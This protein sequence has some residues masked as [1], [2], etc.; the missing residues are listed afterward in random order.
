[1]TRDVLFALLCLVLVSLATG[2]C[3]PAEPPPATGEHRA[4]DPAVDVAPRIDVPIADDPQEVARG[5]ALAGVLPGGF[6]EDL[7][8]YRPS[9]IVD[10]SSDGER[11]V[12]L[13]TATPLADVRSSLLARLEANGWSVAPEAN[14][15][16]LLRQ[17]ERRARLHL[18]SDS[19]TLYRYSY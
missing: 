15:G 10:F 17:G 9:S 2:G 7:P 14:G 8:I 11:W 3:R 19:G 4:P 18:Q 1:M 5:P 12:E 6:P 16:Y 13:L